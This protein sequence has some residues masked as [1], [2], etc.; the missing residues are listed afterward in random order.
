[1]EETAKTSKRF[2]HVNNC[3]QTYVHMQFH[4]LLHPLSVYASVEGVGC[5]FVG[6]IYASTIPRSNHPEVPAHLI[7][8][9]TRTEADQT[10]EILTNQ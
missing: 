5:L 7:I 9:S 10:Y 3:P 2:M 4:S 1:M 6:D 8:G